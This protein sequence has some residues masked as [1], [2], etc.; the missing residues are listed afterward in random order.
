M[1]KRPINLSKK[2]LDV[3]ELYNKNQHDYSDAGGFF[4]E[5]SSDRPPAKKSQII[6]TVADC[7][8]PCIDCKIAIGDSYYYRSFKYPL[9]NDCRKD[10]YDKP[11]Y[12]TINR[13]MAK[14]EFLLKDEDLDY[15]QPP[16]KFISRKNPHNPRYGDM[17]LYL[18]AQLQERAILVH[19]SL[20]ELEELKKDRALKR[21][22]NTEKKFERKINKMRRELRV[23]EKP[24]DLTPKEHHH[25]FEILADSS[26][27]Q[28]QYKKCTECGLTVTFVREDG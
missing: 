16:L 24:V 2:T 3:Q 14:K 25:N 6:M 19:G 26:D 7:S 1:S 15:R 23:N 20:A 12:Q 18:V 10:D 17:K 9:C 22:V 27:D 5:S 4:P 21:E 11:E 8:L 13:T 28:Y